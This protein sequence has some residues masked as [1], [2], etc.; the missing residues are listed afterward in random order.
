MRPF[1]VPLAVRRCAV[2]GRRLGIRGRAVEITGGEAAH[3]ACATKLVEDRSERPVGDLL[4]EWDR[5][6]AV[7]ETGEAVP[8]DDL[9]LALAS[10]DALEERRDRLAQAEAERLDRI[11]ARY[12]AA[13]RPDEDDV[14]A[15]LWRHGGRW[16]WLRL[17][18]RGEAG[19]Y[20]DEE[21][22]GVRRFAKTTAYR[23]AQGPRRVRRH[24][25]DS[26]LAQAGAS[27]T[28]RGARSGSAPACRSRQ[29]YMKPPRSSKS[30]PYLTATPQTLASGS[31]KLK[32]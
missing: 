16:W 22:D 5:I 1:R 21:A 23:S 32:P 14:L 31:R 25:G 12:R 6:A 2:C 3:L 27:R 7:L 13:T 29:G 24:A 9:T 19:A 4:A 10:R 18:A 8:T 17:P 11:D 28:S 20:F 30:E 15:T 26:T